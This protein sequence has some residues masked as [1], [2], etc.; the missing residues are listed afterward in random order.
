MYTLINPLLDNRWAE[1][2]DRH[3]LASAFHR[4]GWL[5]ALART[6]GYQPLVLTRASQNEALTE[7]IVF[8]HVSSW[9]TGARLV[10]LPFTDHCEPLLSDL[11]EARE[12]F[13]W[14]R[15]EYRARWN[16]IELRPLSPFQDGSF[17]LW[18]LRS[19]WYH[20]LDL[21]PSLDNIF[22]RLHKDSIQRKIRRAA[23]EGLTHETGRSKELL[24][25][26]YRLLL[27]TRRRH[28]VLPQPVSWFRNL[29]E[30]MGDNVE[31]R[32]A[33]KSGTAIAAL[34]ILQHRSSIVYKYG[35]SDES[36]HHLGAMPFLF[37]RLIEESKAWG[38]EKLDLGRT[39]LDNEG[40][41]AFKDKF[42][43][44][45][46]LVTYYRHPNVKG[47]APGG[48]WDLQGIRKLCPILPDAV[49]SAAGRV[50]Y[51]HMG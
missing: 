41:I 8:C 51:K 45:K 11:N 20:E 3:P 42:G 28:Y 13:R 37:W 29:V 19:Y 7:G 12:F 22:R 16:Y 35:C 25:E 1:F 15:A 34:L 4:R 31:I 10:S 43:A 27:M 18:P 2:V 30:S 48:D 40:L 9:L 47:V 21:R 26:F 49:F 33:R 5:D 17:D 50:L 6:Y 24:D 32:M 46:R 14:L 36:F 23:R 38:A 44:P 39:D